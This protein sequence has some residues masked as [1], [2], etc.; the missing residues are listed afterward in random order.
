MKKSEGKV[1]EILENREQKKWLKDLEKSLI[2]SDQQ[3]SLAVK[4]NCKYL[5]KNFEHDIK[6][7]LF[8]LG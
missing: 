8:D 1:S 6:F 5:F 2:S 3:M 7:W 4:N